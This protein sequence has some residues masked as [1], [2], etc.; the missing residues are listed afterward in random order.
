METVEIKVGEYYEDCSYHPCVCIRVDGDEL[1]GISLVDGSAGRCCSIINCG[2][3]KLSLKEA[4]ELRFYG[5]KDVEIPENERWWPT[6]DETTHLYI[7]S[8]ASST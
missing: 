8:E 2:V 5:P 6:I 1:F 4:C 7:P 3:V